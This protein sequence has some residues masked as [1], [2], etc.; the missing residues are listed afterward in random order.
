MMQTQKLQ[1]SFREPKLSNAQKVE[2]IQD[3]I[4]GVKIAEIATKYG[5]DKSL[6]AVMA[7]RLG[8]ARR[9]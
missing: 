2:L 1:E 5:V 9:N 4:N 6:P 3:Y 7:K 8:I